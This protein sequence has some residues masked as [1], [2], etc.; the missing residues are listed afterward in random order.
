MS[1]RRR[2][3]GR[4]EGPISRF[5]RAS[6]ATRNAATFLAVFPWIFSHLLIV[7]PWISVP[8]PRPPRFTRR[9]LSN[10]ADARLNGSLVRA[11]TR[12]LRLLATRSQLALLLKRYTDVAPSFSR[13]ERGLIRGYTH[14]VA[15]PFPI[16]RPDRHPAGRKFV[17]D[18]ARDF[19]SPVETVSKI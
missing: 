19:I 13:T 14:Y 8:E 7:L 16:S 9:L 2:E 6:A 12:L 10:A 18:I 17:A 4:E 11:C 5:P 1:E 15:N 3:G